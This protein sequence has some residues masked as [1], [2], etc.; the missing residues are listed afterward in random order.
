VPLSH[1]LA[2]YA[3]LGLV[4]VA[5]GFV[6][7]LAGGGSVLTLPALMLAGM[8]ANL[9][10]GTNRV[11]VLAQS[12]ASTAFFDRAGRLDRRAAIAITVPTLAG[13]LLGASSAALLPPDVLK[14]V[15]LAAMMALAVSLLLF[16]RLLD[17]VEGHEPLTLRE[18]P[19]GALALFAI[20][21]YGGFV[22]AGVGLFLLAA[23]GGLLRYDLV[24]SNALKGIA[25][26]AFTGLSLAVFAGAGQVVWLPGVVLAVGM[27]LGAWLAVRFAVRRGR[28]TLRRLVLGVAIATCVLAWLR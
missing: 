11:A 8:P 24:R 22:Q 18:S 4:G 9:A 15:L 17:P 2:W 7:T 10:N 23:L 25:I 12:I 1:L 14:P 19:K 28:E 26:T 20:G 13:A 3:W 5:A 27:V 21:V 6:N 16:P